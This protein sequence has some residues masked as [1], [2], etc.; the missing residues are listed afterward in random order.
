MSHRKLDVAIIADDLTGALDTAAPFAALGFKTAVR[1]D[2][3]QS[4][5][6]IGDGTQVLSL[7]SESRHLPPHAAEER[8]RL[9]IGAAFVH[10]PR[11]LLKKIDSTLRGNIAIEILACLRWCGRRHALI[12]PAVPSQGRI[13][14]GGEIF[15]DGVPLRQTQIASDALSPPPALTLPEVLSAASAAL[16]VHSWPRG[17]VFPLSIDAGLH[18][19]VADCKTDA[20][21]DVISQLA[22]SHCNEVLPVGASGLGAALARRLARELP[23]K[24][25]SPVASHVGQ[26]AHR[27]ILFVIGSRTAKSVEQMARLHEAGAEELAIPLLASQQ[28]VEQF[29]DRNSCWA[30]PPVALI[31]RPESSE[32]TMK[33]HASEV[34]HRLGRA[35]AGLVRRLKINALVIVGGD[36]AF[37]TFRA[38]AN[39][40]AAISGELVPGIAIGMMQ[41]DGYPVTFVTKAGGFGGADVLIR[42]LQELQ[43]A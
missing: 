18:A 29:L 21:L 10:Q 14:S 1:L 20:D 28:E 43:N 3:D 39:R 11:I 38:L 22:S 8:I 16:T 9:A 40:E 42:I 23:S 19:Y 15:I 7:T 32:K 34:A 35:A 36:T 12:A 33:I 30:A 31:V 24:N 2:V 37:E 17:A 27:P 13:M 5:S 6:T 4:P 26:R 41:V 25:L